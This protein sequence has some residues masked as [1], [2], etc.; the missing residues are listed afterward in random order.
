MQPDMSETS[1]R[2]KIL[3][4][5]AVFAAL[6]AVLYALRPFTLPFGGSIT[7]GSMVPT[8]WLSL[9]RGIKVGCISGAIFGLLALFVDI[10]LLGAANIIVTPLQVILEYPIAFG[11]IGLTGLFRNKSAIVAV[12]GAGLSVFIRFWIHYFVGVFVWSAVYE[13]Q[14]GLWIWPAIYN[15]SFLAVEFIVSAI[16]LYAL[17]KKGTLQYR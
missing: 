16:L 14:Y 6:S 13:F 5:I 15:G 17:V 9:R 8:M 12:A 4:E 2:T 10:L 3:V 1:S 7:L 11:V